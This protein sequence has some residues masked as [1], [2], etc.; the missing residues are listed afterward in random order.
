MGFLRLENHPDNWHLTDRLGPYETSKETWFSHS[1]Y[2]LVHRFLNADVEVYFCTGDNDSTKATAD[3]RQCHERMTELGVPHHFKEFPGGHTWEYWGTHIQEHLEFHAQNFS[4][5]LGK[6]ISQTQKEQRAQLSKWHQRYYQRL[7]L[8]RAENAKLK[9]NYPDRKTIAIVGSSSV[10]GFF[11]QGDLLPGWFLLNRGISGD[12]I[13]LGD[14]GIL[15]HLNESVFDC[16][17]AHVFILNGRND[18]T[19]TMRTGSPEV[20]KVVECYRKVV[21]KILEEIPDVQV[22]IVSCPPTRGKYEKMAP[23][24]YEFDRGL[25]KVARDLDVDYIDIYSKLVGRNQLLKPVHTLLMD[26]MLLPRRIK[27]GPRK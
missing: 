3:N 2:N 18:L 5:R 1:V 26:C 19:N 13:G 6:L 25:K 8:F 9:E 20:N 21:Q 15:T 16:N 23:L 7:E 22:H 27:S 24:V 11:R 4:S 12:K 10:E 14:T 17:P